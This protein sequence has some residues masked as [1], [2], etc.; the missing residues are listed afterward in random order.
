MDFSDVWQTKG[1]TPERD[2]SSRKTV[3]GAEG[4]IRCARSGLAS[5]SD[6]RLRAKFSHVWQRKELE[7]V[8]E[9]GRGKAKMENREEE[10][11][12]GAR[13]TYGLGGVEAESSQFIITWK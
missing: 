3:R 10:A 7:E 5:S 9:G 6:A 12:H 1:L 4:G 11:R 8:K 2:P 13:G